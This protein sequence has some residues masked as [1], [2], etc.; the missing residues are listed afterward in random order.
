MEER[1]TLEEEY[2]NVVGVNP[3]ARAFS[4]EAL[5]A[6]IAA[7]RETERRRLGEIDKESDREELKKL[8]P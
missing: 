8:H 7:G 1:R 2:R 5:R 4:L 6:G 3:L